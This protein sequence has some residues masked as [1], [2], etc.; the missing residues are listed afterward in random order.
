MFGYLMKKNW[1]RT[2]LNS[3]ES[4]SATLLSRLQLREFEIE[5]KYILGWRGLGVVDLF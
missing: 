4:K 2:M 3:A 1:F 5:L